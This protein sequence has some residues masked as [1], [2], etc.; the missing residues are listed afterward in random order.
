MNHLIEIILVA[1]AIIAAA[2]YLTRRIYR[3]WRASAP[4][5]APDAPPAASPPQRL[6]IAGKSAR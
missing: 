6:T 5:T 2:L 3:R 1:L 4:A